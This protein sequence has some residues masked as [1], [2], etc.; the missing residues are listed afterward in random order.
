[1]SA[2]EPSKAEIEALK[3]VLIAVL[4]KT[5]MDSLAAVAEQSAAAVRAAFEKLHQKNAIE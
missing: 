4:P 2:R 1:M 3:E 5:S